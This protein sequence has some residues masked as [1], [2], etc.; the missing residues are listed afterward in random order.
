M[1]KGSYQGFSW[2]WNLRFGYLNFGGLKLLNEKNI[3][4]GIPSIDHP[5]QLCE[6]C[7]YG[8]Q[9]RK[10]FLKEATI[11]SMKPLKLVHTNICGPIKLSSH[12]NNHYFH[13]FIDDF[14]Q[15]T[16]LYFL[17]Q[18]SDA[19]GAFQKFKALVEK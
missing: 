8:K 15:K 14:N 17:K 12:G 16:W 3:V 1:L 19:F 13:L 5:K 7:L 9:S 10:S 4:N 2:L 6:R 18:K 11:R